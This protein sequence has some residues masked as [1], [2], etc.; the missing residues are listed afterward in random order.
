MLNAR[1]KR[2]MFCSPCCIRVPFTVVVRGQRIEESMNHIARLALSAFVSTLLLNS[3]VGAQT[4]A[5]AL[6][7]LH[8]SVASHLAQTVSSA[9][10][11][12][13]VFTAHDIRRLPVSS[14]AEVLAYGL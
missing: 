7:T 13:Q 3:S 11:S 4:P 2:R 14:I 10:R 6:D 9:D 8:V 12:V 5:Y 1:G